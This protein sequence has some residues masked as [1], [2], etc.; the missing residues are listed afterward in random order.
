VAIRPEF[1]DYLMQISADKRLSA[2]KR[3]NNGPELFHN[4]R[5]IVKLRRA[6]FLPIVAKIAARIAS[7]CDFYIKPVGTPA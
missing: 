5:I 1:A 2:G 6:F 3:Q 7:F 4:I